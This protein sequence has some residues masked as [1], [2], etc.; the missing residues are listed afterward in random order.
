MHVDDYGQRRRPYTLV[1]GR[2]A[3][4]ADFRVEALISAVAREPEWVAGLLPHLRTVYE[5]AAQRRVSVAEVSPLVN[6]PLG[7]VRVLIADLVDGGHLEVHQTDE[8]PDRKLLERVLR[9]L[10]DLP[11][12]AAHAG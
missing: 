6:M 11:D 7:V 10:R 1:G 5:L 3:R 4:R 8:R 2:T 12:N 9:G